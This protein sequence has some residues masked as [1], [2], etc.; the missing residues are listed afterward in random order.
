MMDVI[1]KVESTTQYAID[2]VVKEVAQYY[3]IVE[4]LNFSN[5]GTRYQ[6][7]NYVGIMGY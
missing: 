3:Y 2:Q 4:K 7:V 6:K 1:A 5:I